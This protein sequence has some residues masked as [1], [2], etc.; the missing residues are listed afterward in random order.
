[1]TLENLVWISVALFMVHE[2]EELVRIRPWLARHRDDPRAREQGFWSFSGTS[3]STMA[4]MIFEEYVL[5]V[6]FALA[7]VLFH[8]PGMF[9]GLLVAY[10][11]HLLG[12]IAEA[13]RLRMQ[14]PSVISSVITLP[15]YLYAIAALAGRSG[16]IIEVGVW[17]VACIGVMLA[18]FALI[19]RLRP[20]IEARL[21]PARGDG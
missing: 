3:T 17:S 5:F 16:S 10:T 18:N 13:I 11:L 20:I 19:Y 6:L 7:A 1:M 12:H 21:Y 4:A 14:T 2:F 15:W 8:L 9:S